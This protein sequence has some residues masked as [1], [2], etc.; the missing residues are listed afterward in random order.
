MP[1]STSS[2]AA[3]NSS[4]SIPLLSSASAA[5]S[6]SASSFFFSTSAF[7]S[8]SREPRAFFGTIF[9]CCWRRINPRELN[10]FVTTI[11]FSFSQPLM[12]SRIGPLKIL[13]E[14]GVILSMVISSSSVSGTVRAISSM[15]SGVRML[16][17]S[18]KI[19]CSMRREASSS[20]YSAWYCST[21]NR[22]ETSLPNPSSIRP[23]LVAAGMTSASL[24]GVLAGAAFFFLVMV[25]LTAWFCSA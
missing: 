24:A 11:P 16:A 8:A 10:A 1:F 15:T 18:L 5:A 12:K 23:S 25:I 2:A 19:D 14:F 4:S 9:I 20:L 22:G 13:T 17:R 21:G 3:N 6:S 7:A